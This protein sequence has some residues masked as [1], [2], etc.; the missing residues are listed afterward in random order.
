MIETNGAVVSKDGLMSRVWPG[1]IVEDNNLHT[2]IKALRGSQQTPGRAHIHCTGVGFGASSPIRRV[3]AIGCRA[4]NAVAFGGGRRSSAKIRL[5]S[6]DQR[7]RARGLGRTLRI[8]ANGRARL[9]RGATSP[10]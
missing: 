7:R 10:S 4:P 9:E 1:G 5:S 6:A 8:Q 2:Q 3:S